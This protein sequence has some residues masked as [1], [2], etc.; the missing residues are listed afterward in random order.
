MSFKQRIKYES[1]HNERLSFTGG[2]RVTEESHW[3]FSERE[4][5]EGESPGESSERE[6]VSMSDV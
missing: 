1:F 4:F 6:G 2:I 5:S 3:E